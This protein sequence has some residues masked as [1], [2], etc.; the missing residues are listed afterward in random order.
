MIT[1]I[2]F[3]IDTCLSSANS[4]K[5]NCQSLQ[6]L[7]GGGTCCSSNSRFGICSLIL[8]CSLTH[9]IQF[10][11]TYKDRE[12]LLFCRAIQSQHYYVFKTKSFVPKNL[13][14]ILLFILSVWWCLRVLLL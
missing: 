5:N 10:F 12:G 11:V 6:A 1:K 4:L 2:L 14:S 3:L 9:G 7:A 8:W 13:C